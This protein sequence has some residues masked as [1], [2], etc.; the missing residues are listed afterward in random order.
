MLVNICWIL[1]NSVGVINLALSPALGFPE[2]E[3]L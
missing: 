1:S 2:L 3:R